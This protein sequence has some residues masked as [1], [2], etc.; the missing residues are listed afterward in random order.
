MWVLANTGVNC[1]TGY[2]E[3]DCVSHEVEIV[4]G[5]SPQATE[6]FAEVSFS[7]NL[8]LTLS[9]LDSE[10]TNTT[11]FLKLVATALLLFCQWCHCCTTRFV[12]SCRL[13]ENSSK[14]DVQCFKGWMK[15][16]MSCMML[17]LSSEPHWSRGG[18][19]SVLYKVLLYF[20]LL[21]KLSLKQ[22]REMTTPKATLSTPGAMFGMSGWTWRTCSSH[23]GELSSRGVL[24]PSCPPAFPW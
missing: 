7:L 1:Y 16:L 11:I 3:Q 21:S 12:F 23:G 9:H 13:G 6:N 15:Q 14:S 24:L 19:L 5:F 17:L 8:W 20:S 2:R 18:T 22:Q 4:A 10:R